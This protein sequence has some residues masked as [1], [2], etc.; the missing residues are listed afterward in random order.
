MKEQ[1][2]REDVKLTLEDGCETFDEYV[3]SGVRSQDLPALVKVLNEYPK[4]TVLD[5]HSNNIMDPS[6]LVSLQYVKTLILSKNSVNDVSVKS[7]AQG[8]FTTLDVTGNGLSDAF[9]KH[10]ES[11]KHIGKIICEE[12]P[13]CKVSQD[14][15]QALNNKLSGRKPSPSKQGS[16]GN[17]SVVTNR[18][19]M[20]GTTTTI[21]T[22]T[23]S[24]GELNVPGRVDSPPPGPMVH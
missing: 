1:D 19:S 18:Y 8:T 9:L 5:L 11:A 14:K 22:T 21:T 15:L 6:E 12:T 17:N 24:M 16:N 20:L 23:Y 2:I 4:I 7:L 13:N 3:N 10:F